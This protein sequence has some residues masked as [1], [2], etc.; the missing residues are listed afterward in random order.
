MGRGV[1]VTCSVWL[2]GACTAKA[3]PVTGRESLVGSAWML[4][5]PKCCE[6]G[7]RLSW[8]V[9][10]APKRVEVVVG[11]LDPSRPA[12][13]AGCVRPATLALHELLKRFPMTAFHQPTQVPALACAGAS[14]RHAGASASLRRCQS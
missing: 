4:D 6:V 3:N 10:G 11:A 5:V 12:V 2:A 7:R 13:R 14:A 8:R 9:L 1:Y